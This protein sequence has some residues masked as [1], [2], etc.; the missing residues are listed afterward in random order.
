MRNYQTPSASPR[1]SYADHLETRRA[2]LI[3]QERRRILLRR[4]RALFFFVAVAM[5]FAAFGSHRLPVWWLLVPITAFL[6]LGVRLQRAESERT[7]LSRAVDFYER[8]LARLD[9]RWAGMGV[10][11]ERFVDTEHRYAKDLDLFGR[12]SLFELL[13]NARTPMGQEKLAAWL[14]APANP[15]V[16]RGRHE[17]VA[18]LAPRLDLREDIAVLGE[19]AS[20]VIDTEALFA[21]GERKPL[22][23]PSPFRALAWGLSVLGVTA[24]I[25][26]MAI[27]IAYFL[28]WV[29][30][31][32]LPA[33]TI[34]GLEIY[35]LSLGIVYAAILWRLK[36]RTKRIIHEIDRAADDLRLVAGVLRR[37]EA[38]QFT[39]PSL[40]ALRAELDI[41]GWPPSR[42]ISQLNRLIELIDSR[43]NMIIAI[44]GPLLLWDIHL[45]YGIEDWRRVSGPSMRLWLNAIGEI[46]A[47]SS[48]A[49]Y[50][51]DHPGDVFPEFVAEQPCFEG[52]G[53]GHPFIPED[54][55]VRND[56]HLT[57]HLRLLVVSG[58][59][60]SGKSTL[61][62]T[63]GIN[64]VLAHAG[65]PVCARRLRLSPLVVGACIW[66]QD[67]LQNNTSG[68]YAEIT[69]LRCIMES[70]GG[71]IPLLFLLDELLHGTNSHDRRIG[72]EAI[73]RGLVDR[74]AIGLLT[75]HDLALANIVDSLGSRGANVHFEDHLE[76]GSIRFDYCMRAGVVRKSN[77]IELIRSVGL[78]VAGASTP[79]APLS[80]DSCSEETLSRI[81]FP[82]EPTVP[83]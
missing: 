75:T 9:G 37:L 25:P 34:A 68:F 54:R 26:L 82:S 40:A 32:M 56:V 63:V 81:D 13:C 8:A 7:A 3:V 33:K 42:R 59:N 35:F 17:A 78:E 53:L 18:E 36:K 80:H 60:M 83:Q 44:I 57:R 58:S 74:G 1:Q 43:R 24:V 69:R 15:D 55:K 23:Y 14:L 73:C 16:I 48:L 47:I 72:A 41:E 50:Y 4:L 52:E 45:A 79:Y 46:E 38:E 64:A 30:I 19:K 2:A 27:L 6:A 10:T 70:A 49:G 12:A 39:S 31:V 29:G 67:S 76:D 28:G 21:W 61:L 22:L 62:R 66:T 5:A 51:Y 20:A 77:A 11:G 65:A 71:S